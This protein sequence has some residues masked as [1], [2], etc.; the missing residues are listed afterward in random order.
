M[1]IE[2][3]DAIGRWSVRVK[4]FRFPD[5][6]L[7]QDAADATDELGACPFFPRPF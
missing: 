5:E 1:S 6:L 3:S 4:V 7:P 2:L